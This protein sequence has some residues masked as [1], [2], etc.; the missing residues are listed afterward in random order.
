M[1]KY[2]FCILMCT[3]QACLVHPSLEKAE[4]LDGHLSIY[5]SDQINWWWCYFIYDLFSTSNQS[6]I[7]SRVKEPEELEI[8]G[9]CF[10]KLF[11][12]LWNK[13]V[14]R[15]TQIGDPFTSA[16]QCYI[17]FFLRNS[18]STKWFKRIIRK[19][20]DNPYSKSMS[21]LSVFLL[22]CKWLSS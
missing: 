13:I 17:N 14:F 4:K 3:R 1:F 22:L 15:S 11:L 6:F 7:P 18:G 20:D 21:R 12:L 8:E 5:E 2:L 9:W 19:I 10:H 16:V